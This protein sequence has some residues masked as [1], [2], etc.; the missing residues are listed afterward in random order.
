MFQMYAFVGHLCSTYVAAMIIA[1]LIHYPI[2]LG[3][4]RAASKSRGSPPGG[5]EESCES[6]NYSDDR[7]AAPPPAGLIQ[8]LIASELRRKQSDSVV[9]PK[10]TATLK[11][12]T[13]M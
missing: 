7:H 1:V 2:T 11:S 4:E 8:E 9:A 10:N 12:T 13:E 5:S 3:F 6:T